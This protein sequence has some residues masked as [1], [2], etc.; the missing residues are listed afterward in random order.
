MVLSLRAILRPISFDIRVEARTKMTSAPTI[1]L[2]PYA[3]FSQ[4]VRD[5]GLHGEPTARL[6]V[7][8]AETSAGAS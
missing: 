1:S 3:D 6:R 7:R 2:Q 5:S 4:H 8:Y